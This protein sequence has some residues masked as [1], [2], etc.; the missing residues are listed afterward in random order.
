MLY[1]NALGIVLARVREDVQ[2]TDVLLLCFAPRIAPH[3][4][5]TNIS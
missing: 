5:T 3:L 4:D 2:E 1:A